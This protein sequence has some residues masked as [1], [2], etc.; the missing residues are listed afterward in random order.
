MSRLRKRLALTVLLLLAAGCQGATEKR[1]AG[2]RLMV[3]AAASLTDAFA[4]IE[5]AFETAH[6]RVDAVL[7]LGA[8]STLREQILGGAPVDVFAAADARTM[9]A[10]VA[11]GLI[12]DTPRS[13]ALNRLAIAVP[14][15]NPADLVGLEDFRRTELLIGL[16]AIEVPCGS[17]ARRVLS[18]AGVDASPDSSEPNVRALLAK[19]EIGEL[20][21]GLVYESDTAASDLVERL[22]I[23]EARNAVVDYPIAIV[24]GSANRHHA[25][26]FVDFVLAEKGRAI[27]ERH[28]FGLP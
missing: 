12:A 8:S 6:P 5:R 27:L 21:A 9:D 7:N 22:P 25:A 14:K 10:V 3:S 2:A 17:L 18:S 20:D 26:A 24:A 15:G 13:F 1:A 4:E 11:A 19:L 16:C 28:G 23:P